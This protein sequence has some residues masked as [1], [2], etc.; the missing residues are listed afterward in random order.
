VKLSFRYLDGAQEKD[1]TYYTITKL[2]NFDGTLVLNPYNQVVVNAVELDATPAVGTKV[3]NAT[4][5]ATASLTG[6]IDANRPLV[7]KADGLYFDPVAQV[8]EVLSCEF[9]FADKT[10]ARSYFL[11]LRQLFI[12]WNYLAAGSP[13]F[14]AQQSEITSK[15]EEKRHA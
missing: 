1:K 6:K 9:D 5:D 12:D 13:D 3:V 7:A 11:E 15:I 2:N 10:E 14:A 8:G 4:V